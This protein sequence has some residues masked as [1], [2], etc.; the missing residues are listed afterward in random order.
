MADDS[1]DTIY[2]DV[3]PRLDEQAADEAEQ[4]LRDKFKDAAKDIGDNVK[5][6][7]ENL[8]DHV[9]DLFGKNNIRD[10]LKDARGTIGDAL[11]SRLICWSRRKSRFSEREGDASAR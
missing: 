2:V 11:G 4:K 8:G 9:K 3:K 6:A 7:F 5:G 10:A 1:D